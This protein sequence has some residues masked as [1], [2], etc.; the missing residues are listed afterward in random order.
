MRS[1]IA[2]LFLFLVNAAFAQNRT[3]A[4]T[5]DDLP[6]VLDASPTFMTPAERLAE[7]RRVNRAILKG[8]KKHHAWAIAFVNEKKVQADGATQQNRAILNEWITSGNELGNHTFAHSDLNDMNLEQFEREVLDGEASI[9]PLMNRVG[10]PLHY[11]RFPFNHSGETE[12]KHAAV[13]AFLRQRGYEVATCTVDNTDWQFARVYKQMLERKDKSGGKRLRDAYLQ[14]TAQELAYYGQ[15]YQQIFGH[16]IPLVMLLHV[17]RLN[18]DVIDQALQI[19]ERANYSFVTLE[20][21]QSDHAYQTPEKHPTPYGP[22]WG[23]RWART[24]GVK[25]DGRKEPTVPEWVENYK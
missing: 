20:Q 7:T 19:F 22:M 1:E 13:A 18:A 2:L 3:V 9:N 25:V 23:Y 16:E 11:F 17:N 5:F 8:L 24:L 21:A 15:L 10:R 12:E 6:L 14:F 4:L